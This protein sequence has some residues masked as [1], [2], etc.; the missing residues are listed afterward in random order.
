MSES[1]NEQIQALALRYSDCGIDESIIREMMD[2]HGKPSGLDERAKLIGVRM[3]LG[4]EFHRQEYFSVD[5]LCHV[6]GETPE[7]AMKRMQEAGVSPISITPAPWLKGGA[8]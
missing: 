8:L 1:I 5:D 4:N 7:E 2:D 6:T 3:C